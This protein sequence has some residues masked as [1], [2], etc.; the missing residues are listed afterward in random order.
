MLTKIKIRN[1]KKLDAEIELED[2]VVF[3]GPNNSGKTSALQAISL[4]ELGMRRWAQKIEK[5]KAT[6]RV[7]AIINRRDILMTPISQTRLLWKDT[8]IRHA[9]RNTLIEIEVEGFS[10]NLNWHVGFEFDY[11]NPDSVYCRMSQDSDQALKSV[12]LRA[13]LKERI[14]Y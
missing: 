6:K 13:A 5:S 14:G 9:T 4:W 11:A 8:V 7:A 12:F 3:V 2:V 10:S 1:F